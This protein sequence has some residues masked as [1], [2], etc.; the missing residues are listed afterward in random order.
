MAAMHSAVK[1]ARGFADTDCYKR[2]DVMG[3]FDPVNRQRVEAVRVGPARP[4][5]A[6]EPFPH[7]S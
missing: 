6:A 5:D 4:A 2:G 7:A 3:Y 1:V